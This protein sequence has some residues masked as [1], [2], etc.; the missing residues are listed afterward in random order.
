M[1][2]RIGHRKYRRPRRYKNNY[3]NDKKK[4]QLRKLEEVRTEWSSTL[5]DEETERYSWKDNLI[6]R[7]VLAGRRS[8]S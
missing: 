4:K 8:T 6:A 5:L 2:S 3:I 1:K 7:R